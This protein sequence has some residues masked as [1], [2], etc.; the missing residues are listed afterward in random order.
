MSF[1]K[2]KNPLLHLT[3]ERFTDYHLTQLEGR[4]RGES[5][6]ARCGCTFSGHLR[7]RTFH[8]CPE[9]QKAVDEVEALKK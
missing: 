8:R 2:P 6:T 7:G 3:D 1:G 4:M 9:H 5:F